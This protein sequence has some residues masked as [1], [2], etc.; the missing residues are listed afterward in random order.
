M[1]NKM[2]YKIFSKINLQVIK[3]E[4]IEIIIKT[5]IVDISLKINSLGKE[6]KE[7]KVSH[8]ENIIIN[9]NKTI[10]KNL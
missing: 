6:E 1:E 4:R 8:L 10:F 5:K 3:T 9:K 2:K 7:S